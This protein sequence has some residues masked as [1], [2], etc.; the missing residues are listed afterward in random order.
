MEHLET[1][2]D[3]DAKTGHKTA[4][5]SFCGYKTHI[6]MTEERIITAATIT[7][8][9]KTD[10]KELPKLVQKSKAAGIQIESVIGDMAYSEKKNIEAAKE[11]DYELAHLMTKNGT[12][13]PLFFDTK[14]SKFCT[15]ARGNSNL[16]YL[17]SDDH[18]KFPEAYPDRDPLYAGFLDE[19]MWEG[20]KGYVVMQNKDA[21]QARSILHFDLTCLVYYDP[22]FLK[23]RITAID[24]IPL[25]SELT[26]AECFGMNRTFQM[27]YFSKGDKLYYYDLQNKREQEVKRVGGQPAVPAGEKI[28]MIKHIIFDNSYSAP[29]EYTNKLVIATGNGSNYKLYLFDTSADKVKD[30]PEVYQGEGIPSEVM[31]MSSKMG[32]GYLCY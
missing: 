16:L 5:T 7:S 19:G 15:V 13:S 12:M 28:V 8:G 6:A 27:L 26:R 11:G 14:S 10:G 20:G 23:N 21:A 2:K 24:E 18:S 32:N 22:A 30:N 4:D 9:E 17:N 29:D 31:Y 3:E 25:E 1:S